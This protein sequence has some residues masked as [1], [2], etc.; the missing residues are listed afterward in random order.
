MEGKCNCEGKIRGLSTAL[1]DGETVNSFGR[2][3]AFFVIGLEENKDDSRSPSGMTT[4]KATATA[5]AKEERQRQLRK[6][7]GNGNCKSEIRGTLHC[8]VHG[9]TVNSF[10][11]DDAF[12]VIGLE[13][14]K[15]DKQRLMQSAAALSW[16]L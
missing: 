1:I 12:F 10:G 13:E 4:R 9:E 14:N 11:R 16:H 8:A 2:D 7:K 15:N 6:K 3:D 5:T